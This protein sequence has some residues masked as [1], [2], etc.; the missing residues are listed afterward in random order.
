M[1]FKPCDR[2][3]QRALTGSDRIPGPE[4]HIHHEPVRSAPID[5]G[6]CSSNAILWSPFRDALE[7]VKY[8]GTDASPGLSCAVTSEALLKFTLRLVIHKDH[9]QMVVLLR[10]NIDSERS[11]LLFA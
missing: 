6:Q 10:D 7:C 9:K 1:G 3:G 5:S 4:F 2:L 11:Q 8:A